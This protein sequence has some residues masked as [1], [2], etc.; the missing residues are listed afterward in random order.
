MHARLRVLTG[1]GGVGKTTAATAFALALA[2]CGRRVLVA[3]MNGGDRV[4]SILGAQPVGSEL[5]EVLENF[6]VVDMNPRDAIREYVILRFRFEAVYSSVF[7]NR[8]VKQFLRL[9]PSLGELVMLGK[10]WFHHQETR[11]DGTPRFHDIVLDAPST[12]H[13]IA[14]L[15]APS[16]VYETVPPGS[17]RD[18]AQ[19]IAEMI[20]TRG[21]MH[22]VTLPEDMSVDEA[23]ALQ[24][25]AKHSIEIPLG[26]S[27]IN[28]RIDPVDRDTIKRL[29]RSPDS[30]TTK[31]GKTLDLR[32]C[33][34][35]QGEECLK[36]LPDF[37]LNDSVSF[38]ILT[39]NH[40]GKASI[41]L[42]AEQI[43]SERSRCLV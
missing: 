41:E 13:A 32:Q 8:F 6:Y 21:Q 33:A 11:T 15:N 4:A 25:A 17:L 37:M 22:I 1:K 36:R 14:A 5:R 43:I 29:R 20:R 10:L 9:I 16:V 42:L 31:V 40:I 18:N 27:F 24:H 28:R 39:E 7:E 35:E 38:P 26:T 19:Q 30:W 2:K 34:F 12:G 3:E 23:L